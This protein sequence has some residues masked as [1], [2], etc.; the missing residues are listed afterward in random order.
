MAFDPD[1][2]DARSADAVRGILPAVR[3]ANAWYLRLRCDGLEHLDRVAGEPVL[4]VG[5][6]NGGMTGPDVACTLG[7]LW[8]AFGA[9]HPLYALAH[10]YVMRQVTPFGRLI[11]RYGALRACPENAARALAAGAKVLVYPGGDIEAFRASRRRDEIVLGERTGFVRVAQ[12]AGV[13]VVPVVAHGAH[14]SAWILDDGE[15]LVRAL[16]LGRRARA[17]RFPLALALPW[18][19]A[20]GPWVPYFPLPF[21]IRLRVLPPMRFSAREDP[22]RGREAVRARMQSALDE[23]AREARA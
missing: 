7:T 6:H 3:A 19:I 11:Q 13:A 21:R 1:R 23:L 5:N 12:R 9:E 2:L 17:N 15:W 16:D 18:G 4:F 22:R 14:R 20:V 10:D 8:D